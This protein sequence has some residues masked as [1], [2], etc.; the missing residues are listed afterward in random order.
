MDALEALR[1]R[2][3][4]RQFTDRNIPREL[5]EQVVDAGRLAATPRNEQPSEFVVLPDA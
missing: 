2:R 3:S 5:V 4:C 1:T